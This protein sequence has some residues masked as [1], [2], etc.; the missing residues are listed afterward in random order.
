MCE[1]V[2]VWGGGGGGGE[3]GCGE[4]GQRGWCVR[5][6]RACRATLRCPAASVP[7]QMTH[8]PTHPP[9]PTHLEYM[10]AIG[11]KVLAV[12]WRGPSTSMAMCSAGK[13]MS[14]AGREGG[15]VSVC[16]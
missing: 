14:T 4:D 3:R 6:C 11:L 9:L 7:L 8:P 1:C 13:A 5:G 12:K 10:S 15:G 16:V 2:C